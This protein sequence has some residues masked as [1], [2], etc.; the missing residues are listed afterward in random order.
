MESIPEKS[1]R[2]P[3]SGLGFWCSEVRY[4]YGI[5]TITS[6]DRFERNN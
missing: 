5:E 4:N 1:T 6:K 2:Q 3:L